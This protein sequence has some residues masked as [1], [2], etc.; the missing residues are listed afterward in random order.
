MIIA[1]SGT[2]GAGKTFVA[3][4]LT[5]AANGK[6]EYFDLNKYIKKNKLYES[7]DRK[8]RTFDVD[9]KLLKKDINPTLKKSLS[10]ERL[11][12][13]IAGKSVNI[14][15]LLKILKKVSKN[16]DGIIVDSHLSHYLDS[17]YCIIVRTDLKKLYNRLKERKYPKS[18]IH[19]NIE[20]EIFEVCLDEARKLK[21][22]III[23]EN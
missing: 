18:K 22:K 1:I 20:A 3:K 5:G 2:P 13:S 6:F 21:R 19:D 23:V 4:K 16:S 15:M 9:I 10:K 14:D 8:D 17:D 7:Y 12:D 11:M